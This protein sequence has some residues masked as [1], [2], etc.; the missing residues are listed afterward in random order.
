MTPDE[1]LI[2]SGKLMPH[3]GVG[4]RWYRRPFSLFRWRDIKTLL[5]ETSSAWTR[6]NAP[7][8][9]AALAFYTMFSLT[10]LILIVVSI[11][12]MVFGRKAAE[13]QIVW[14]VRHL[15]GATGANAI[16]A[17]LQGATDTAHGVL[18]SIIGFGTLLIGASAMFVELRD[19]MNTIWE[20]PAAEGSGLAD[21]FH[22]VKERLFSFS[23]ILAIGFLLLTSLLINA[24]LAA[25]SRYSSAAIPLPEVVLQL[26]NDLISFAVLTG[27]FAAIFKVIPEIRVEWRD[28]L[29]GAVVTSVL[30]TIGKAG[31]GLYLGRASFASTYG[32]A[33]SIVV[34]ILWVYYSSQVFFLGAEFTRSFAHRFGSRPKAPLSQPAS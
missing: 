28:V 34:F 26:L 29:L 6:H 30:F 9:G 25:F 4:M 13:G 5:G 23:L 33:A 27:L 10:P 20:V 2:P 21:L 32:A 1:K 31:I 15:V 3:P 7:R 8:L 24:G 19:A 22:I 12:G 17:I 18:A 16:L 11:A 14:Q